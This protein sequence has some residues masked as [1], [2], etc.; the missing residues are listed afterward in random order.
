[1]QYI[2]VKCGLKNVNKF[3]YCPPYCQEFQSLHVAHASSPWTKIGGREG[4]R[5]GGWEVGRDGGRKEG[6]KEERKAEIEKE[7]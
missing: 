5:E 6:K 1:M 2:H 7:R 3:K 4:G